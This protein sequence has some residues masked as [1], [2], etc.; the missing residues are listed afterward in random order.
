MHFWAVGD[1]LEVA[2]AKRFFSILPRCGEQGDAAGQGL[3]YTDGGNA[4][5]HDRVLLARNVQRKARAAVDGGGLKVGKVA[6]VG[7]VGL[8]EGFQAWGGVTHAEDFCP[9]RQRS[10]GANQKLADLCC[11]LPFAPVANPHDLLFSG[12]V[13]DGVE[14]GSIG[15]FVESPDMLKVEAIKVDA[16]ER[17]AKGEDTI[18]AVEAEESEAFRRR[19][20]AVVSVVEEELKVELCPKRQEQSGQSRRVPLMQDDDLGAAEALTPEV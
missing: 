17:F 10:C 4:G 14:D 18:K 6:A 2:G 15:C 3:E 5:H 16:A 9:D 20:G 19:G 8:T 12:L 1:E 13:G 11:T 7:D